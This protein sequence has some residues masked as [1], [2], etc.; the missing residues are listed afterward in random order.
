MCSVCN[1]AAGGPPL[2]IDCCWEFSHHCH[3][4]FSLWTSGSPP[5]FECSFCAYSVK[6]INTWF[7]LQ[8]ME[9]LR[10]LFAYSNIFLLISTVRFI[11]S[12]SCLNSQSHAKVRGKAI[13]MKTNTILKFFLHFETKMSICVQCPWGESGDLRFCCC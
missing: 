4:L 3:I 7:H 10:S 8:R 1:R 2:V 6:L 5:S 12:F 13:T 9:L 11:F